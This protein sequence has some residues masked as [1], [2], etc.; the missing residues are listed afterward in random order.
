MKVDDIRSRANQTAPEESHQSNELDDFDMV[1]CDDTVTFSEVAK[2][3]NLTQDRRSQEDPKDTV[4]PP[5]EKHTTLSPRYLRVKDSQKRIHR[6]EN[7]RKTRIG[8][9]EKL[10][11]LLD[12]WMKIIYAEYYELKLREEVCRCLYFCEH[13]R[14]CCP[15][16]SWYN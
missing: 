9:D 3:R 2:E 8:R 7:F 6:K 14:G 12:A 5:E 16:H 11:N 15:V 13:H 10:I 1:N 4:K